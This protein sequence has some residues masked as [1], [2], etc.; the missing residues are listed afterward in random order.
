LTPFAVDPVFPDCVWLV[1][2]YSK[3][4]SIWVRNW[5]TYIASASY[6]NRCDL[7]DD[8]W[9]DGSEVTI[10]T[11]VALA[12]A[13]TQAE[14]DEADDGWP[15]D[16]NDDRVV[17]FGDIG[18]LTVRFGQSV[19]PAPSRL[20]INDPPDGIIN[21]GDIGRVISIFGANC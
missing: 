11:G 5:G 8:G 15:A 1:S 17:N 18:Q 4:T 21:F 3:N 2:E 6:G 16:L 12:C 19:P 10:G 14:N 7:D 20:N 13:T 9:S